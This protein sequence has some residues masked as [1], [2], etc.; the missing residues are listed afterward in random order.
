MEREEEQIYKEA[1]ARVSFRLH[2][3]TYVAINILAW[4][5][6]YF[7]EVRQ[8]RYDGFWPVYATLGWGFGVFAHYLNAYKSNRSAI[9][10][11]VEKIKRE[12]EKNP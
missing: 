12:R 2:L 10:L 11:E 9:E 8:G 3:K 7:L 6:W 4:L 5:F 1:E